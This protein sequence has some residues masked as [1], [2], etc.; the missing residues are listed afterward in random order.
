MHG[1]KAPPSNPED[2]ATHRLSS[3]EKKRWMFAEDLYL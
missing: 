3:T 2:A 1:P